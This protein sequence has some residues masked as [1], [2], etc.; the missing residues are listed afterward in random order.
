MPPGSEGGYAQMPASQQPASTSQTA[1]FFLSNYRLGKTLG[2]GSFGKARCGVV[3]AGQR[4]AARA[5]ERQKEKGVDGKNA[6]RRSSRPRRRST[7]Q[8]AKRIEVVVNEIE[9]FLGNSSPLKFS[10]HH[11]GGAG[12]QGGGPQMGR[13]RPSLSPRRFGIGGRLPTKG[14]SAPF[15][16]IS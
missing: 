5:R 14:V 13:A 9:E 12:G 10:L 11:R 1:E 4:G 2:I 3:V 16:G 7:R 8:T 15:L 6:P